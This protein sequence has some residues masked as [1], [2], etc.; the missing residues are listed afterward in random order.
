MKAV[1][2]EEIYLENATAKFAYVTDSGPFA[3]AKTL[4][5]YPGVAFADLFEVSGAV[6]CMLFWKYASSSGSE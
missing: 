5:S 2:E 1:E 6:K 4:E 3:E